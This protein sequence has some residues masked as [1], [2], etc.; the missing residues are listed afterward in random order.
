M[1]GC[2]GSISSGAGS[3][4]RK[5]RSSQ[6][7]N[8][9]RDAESAYRTALAKGELGLV[10]RKPAPTLE[11]F[12]KDRV[13]PWAE[14]R[15]EKNTWRWYQ[16]GLKAIYRNPIAKLPLDEITSEHVDNFAAARKERR[17]QIASVERIFTGSSAVLRLALKWKPFPRFLRSHR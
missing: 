10:E 8:A 13:G 2:T 1:A 4:S 3:T 6:T 16:A 17:V 5:V 11:K 7:G 14:P 12:C 9:A 15:F